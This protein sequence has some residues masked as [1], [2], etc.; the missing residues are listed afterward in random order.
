MSS[1]NLNQCLGEW[2]ADQRAFLSKCSMY[3]FATM[4]LTGDPI[5]TPS[6]CSQNLFW[7]EK[8]V[9]CR[10]N[11]K[12]S[13]IFCTFSTVLSFSFSSFSNKSLIMLRAGSIGTEVKREV[14]SYAV[15]HSPSWRVTLLALFTKSLEFCIWWG[16]LPTRGFNTLMRTLLPHN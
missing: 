4:G 11:P 9:L 2:K 8:W 15:R 5:A 6:T 1:T 13:M 12:S 7:K 14:T 10:Q 3:R 16:D